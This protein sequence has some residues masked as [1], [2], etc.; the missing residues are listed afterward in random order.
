VINSA[1]IILTLVAAPEAVIP[2]DIEICAGDPAIFNIG[3]QGAYSSV[4]WSTT[5]D[6]TLTV[7]NDVEVSYDP[8]PNDIA[9]QFVV[10][11]VTVQSSFPECGATTYNIPV[12]IND[13]N[14]PDLETNPPTSPLCATSGVLDLNDLFV[15]GDPGSWSILSTPPGSN[16]AVI[17]GSQFMVNNSDAGSYVVAYNVSFP[18][19]GCPASS[20]ETIIVNSPIVPEAGP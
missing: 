4:I 7:V 10:I 9:A 19:P 13:C 12:N 8:G 1:P 15:V 16:P 11:S 14:C 6:G 2:Q 18:Q 20:M 17:V 3:L 5:G